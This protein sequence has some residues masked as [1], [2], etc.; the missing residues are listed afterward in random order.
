MILQLKCFEIY[1][2]VMETFFFL[3]LLGVQTKFAFQVE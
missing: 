3:D 1:V 2:G